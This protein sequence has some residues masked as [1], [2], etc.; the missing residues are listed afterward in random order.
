MP[1][2]N[3][4]RSIKKASGEL[5]NINYEEMTYEGYGVS[6]VAVIVEALSDNKNRTAGE[7]RHA[8]DKNG[9]SMGA[10][11]CVSCCLLYTSRSV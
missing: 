5:G 8:F 1:N 9:G 4:A 7:V 6:G 11:G 10:T 2:D 3:I